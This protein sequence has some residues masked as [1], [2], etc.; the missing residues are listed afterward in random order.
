RYDPVHRVV[1]V[2]SDRF[3]V[4][5]VAGLVALW[6]EKAIA[7]RIASENLA[8]FL[9]TNFMKPEVLDVPYYFQG[10]SNWCWAACTAMMLK[11][12]ANRHID[13]WRLGQAFGLD[14]LSG[15]PN[16]NGYWFSGLS[17]IY[18][19]ICPDPP[20]TT[21]L[22]RLPYFD[23]LE[24]TLYALQQLKQGRAVYMDIYGLQHGIIAV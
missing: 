8:W 6:L 20:L 24:A 12:H 17:T 11:A 9:D 13:L 4:I 1:E 3:S 5:A 23:P 14:F 22:T 15:M 21:E 18:E 16:D 19:L 10:H 2:R 7:H